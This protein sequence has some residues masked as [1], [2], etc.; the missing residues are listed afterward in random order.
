[1]KTKIK[2]AGVLL[3]FVTALLSLNSC[4]DMLGTES[5][6]IAFEDDNQLGSAND[7]IYSV[8]GILSQL[9]KVGERYVLLGELRGDLM[10]VSNEAPFS[11]KEINNFD[12][13]SEN[14]YLD[15]RSYYEII[16]N[17]NYA[18]AR[19]DT[20]ITVRNEKVMLPEF[21]AIKTIR[22]WTYFQIAQIYGKATYITEPILD[23]EAAFKEYP[24]MG[25][26][27]L[28]PKLID[29]LLPYINVR[30]LDYGSIDGQASSQF[31]IPIPM[32][33][34]D[35]YLYRNEYNKAASMYYKLMFDKKYVISRVYANVWESATR[36]KV[37]IM[38]LSSY[39]NEVISQIAYSSV[40]KDFHSN[41]VN[42]SYNNVTT[43][44]PAAKFIDEMAL[45][46]HFFAAKYDGMITATFEGDLRGTMKLRS[47]N[48]YI[49]EIGD[50]YETVNIS[51]IGP[52]TLIKKYL[53]CAQPE[54]T[55]PVDE[56]NKLLGSAYILTSIPLYRQPH[57]YLRFAE[58]IN[59]AGK[60]T[61]AFAVL[62]YGLTEEVISNP[63]KVNA[64]E[65][66][67][68]EPYLDFSFSLDNT[69]TACRGL[70]LG[71]TKDVT[72]FVIPDYSGASSPAVARQDSID[73]VELKILEEMAAETAYEGNRFFDLLRISRHR[74]NSPAF[75]A[76][77]VAA[78][79]DNPEAMKSKLMNMEAWFLK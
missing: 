49:G 76:E 56:N 48:T 16:N 30:N 50:S 65:L 18:I 11:L 12:I 75:M 41:L 62:K 68:G 25:L 29:E 67:S 43:L 45:R 52:K 27:E 71:I 60:P 58:A 37:T 54:Y 39:Y 13:T 51:G 74:G 53:N 24:T 55:M 14:T 3:T 66:E 4:E 19:M 1:M 69:G 46:P 22:A 36:E 17:C 23:Y 42:M 63:K 7:S 73:W 28:V 78:K 44:L 9:Q 47:N 57:L 70:G 21:A 15:K 34:G 79:F 40:P 20:T 72:N 33:L 77:K 32:L 59:R 2:Y 61:L 6:R 31:F 5:S 8:M 26:D 64:A 35:L 10:T 38:H